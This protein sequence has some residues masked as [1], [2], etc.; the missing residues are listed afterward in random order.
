MAVVNTSYELTN[1]S[2]LA[3]IMK[4]IL[5]RVNITDKRA[6]EDKPNDLYQP[7]AFGS[8]DRA[9]LRQTLKSRCNEFET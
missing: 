8:Y 6:T 3:A 5:C 1:S 9:L 4:S 7:V 2:V